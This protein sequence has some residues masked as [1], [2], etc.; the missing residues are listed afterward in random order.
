LVFA[1]GVGALFVPS[2]T[3]LLIFFKEIPIGVRIL[4]ALPWIIGLLTAILLLFLVRMWREGNIP[5]WALV[6]YILVV[7]SA[8][9]TVW[10]ANFWNLAL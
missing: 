8:A 3:D 5:L 4:F 10:L 7:L 1:V 2:I 6:H 9:A